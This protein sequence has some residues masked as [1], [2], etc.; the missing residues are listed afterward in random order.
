MIKLYQANTTLLISFDKNDNIGILDIRNLLKEIILK[1]KSPFSNVMVD[2]KG[3]NEIDEQGLRIV[4]LGKRLA[5]MSGSQ[6]SMYNANGKLLRQ[7]KEGRLYQT[8][9]FCDHLSIAS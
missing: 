3:I 6:M 8:V 9:F 7:I 1:L 4:Q 2:L 5:E